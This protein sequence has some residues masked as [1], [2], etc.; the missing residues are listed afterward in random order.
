MPVFVFPSARSLLV[1]QIHGKGAAIYAQR[2]NSMFIQMQAFGK[3][4]RDPELKVTKDGTPH[5]ELRPIS[6]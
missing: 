6:A 3:V 2:S 1:S 4:E 5:M